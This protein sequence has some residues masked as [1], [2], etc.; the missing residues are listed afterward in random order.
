MHVRKTFMPRWWNGRHWRLKISWPETAVRVRVPLAVH[1]FRIA[2]NLYYFFDTHK[3]Y[4]TIRLMF[5]KIFLPFAAV[6]L[7]ALT[8]CSGKLGALSADNFNV[9]P[10]PMETQGGSVPVTIN[11]NF[12]EK[13]M[14]K[15][16]VVTVTPELRAADAGS[17]PG[18]GGG[19]PRPG[20]GDLLAVPGC[21]SSGGTAVRGGVCKAQR[22]YPGGYSL[23]FQLRRL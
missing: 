1:G 11:G 17:G 10:N 20:G 15:K 18:H 8:S 22:L 14:K 23:Q 2:N 13:Y 7:L 16:A 12:P 21:G 4:N 3:V 6:A 19:P 5:K 9:N